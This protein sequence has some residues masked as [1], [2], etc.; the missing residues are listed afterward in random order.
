[1]PETP[2]LPDIG[3]WPAV[4]DD[5]LRRMLREIDQWR[6]AYKL[7]RADLTQLQE[8]TAYSGYD[9]AFAMVSPFLFIF[10][11]ALRAAKVTGELRTEPK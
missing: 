5:I 6:E 3:A 2:S 4:E 10:A 1:M 7:R 11:L 8:Q 9:E